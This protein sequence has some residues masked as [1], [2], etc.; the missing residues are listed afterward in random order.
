V[1]FLNPE[2]KKEEDGT[3]PEK[4]TDKQEIAERKAAAV[5]VHHMQLVARLGIY[6]NV[7]SL[8]DTKPIPCLKLD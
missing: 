3:R 2:N 8:L 4:T 7:L 6:S 1:I 5:A